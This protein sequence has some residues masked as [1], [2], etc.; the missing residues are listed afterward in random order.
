MTRDG[1]MRRLAEH[2]DWMRS[3]YPDDELADRLRHR[4]HDRR[5]PAPRGCT[6]SSRTTGRTART[7]STASRS[8]TWWTTR[9]M[10]TRSSQPV[11]PAGR[12]PRVDGR[13]WY[14]EHVRDPEAVAASHRPYQGVSGVIRWFQLQAHTHVALNTGRAGSMRDAHARLA[15][16]ARRAASCRGS[17]ADLLFMNR[18]CE[19]GKVA[20]AKIEALGQLRDAG[21]RVVA[22]VD[23]EPE[24]LQA[25][26]EADVTGEIMFLHADTIFA[27]RR[28]PTPSERCRAPRSGLR[29][30]S[31]R[32]KWD[33]AWT[34]RLARCE[35]RTQ[36]PAV[37]GVREQMGGGRRP[38]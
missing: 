11:R 20:S 21:F 35:R 10:S 5:C 36:P 37:P 34:L 15:Q 8:P 27:S 4:R 31:T 13:T 18:G 6:C 14:L 24:M 17:I 33:G 9:P 26:F 25:M 23:N 12:R 7:S 2:V 19:E 30:W 28:Q 3:S 29:G 22:V 16:R 38:Q 1:W 32:Q